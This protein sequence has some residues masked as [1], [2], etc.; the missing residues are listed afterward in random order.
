MVYIEGI[1]MD[2]QKVEIVS[3]W[4]RPTNV[5]EIHNFLGMAGYYRRFVKDFSIIAAPLTQ[6]TCKQLKFE[7]NIKCEQSFQLLKNCLTSAPI[8]SLPLGQEEFVVYCGAS[9]VGLEYMF[10]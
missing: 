10:M 2:P 4:P 8:L 1:H 6:L 7:W 9:H 3:N 5:T